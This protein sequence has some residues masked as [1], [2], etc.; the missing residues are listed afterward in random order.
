MTVI[1]LPQNRKQR[2]ELIEPYLVKIMREAMPHLI[3]SD[4][5]SYITLCLNIIAYI[6]VPNDLLETLYEIVQ[7]DSV[8][9]QALEPFILSGLI[10]SLPPVVLK[11]L[12]QYYVKG[13]NHPL[14]IW[15]IMVTC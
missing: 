10:L 2:A 5:E 6:A 3:Q 7:D 11:A 1:G 12:I 4:R 14:P 15:A 8:F 13:E 9:F